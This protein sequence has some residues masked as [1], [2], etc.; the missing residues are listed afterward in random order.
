MSL[1]ASLSAYANTQQGPQSDLTRPAPLW[2][3][4]FL[5]SRLAAE[6]GQGASG[7]MPL[8]VRCDL[9]PPL[10]KVA[11]AAM[12]LYTHRSHVDSFPL[13][14][15]ILALAPILT[16]VIARSVLPRAISAWQKR[17]SAKPPPLLVWSRS[18]SS[19]P[20]M[21]RSGHCPVKVGFTG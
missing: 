7:P 8:G 3:A 9:R 11:T 15:T 19:G 2:L 6:Q 10:P 20:S 5:E 12:L 18:Q 4:S 17:S 16:E 13:I 14:F 21:T 1:P